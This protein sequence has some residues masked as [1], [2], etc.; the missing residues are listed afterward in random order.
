M[1]L[2]SIRWRREA[3]K[4]EAPEQEEKRSKTGKQNFP[5]VHFILLYGV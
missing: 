2:K 5:V 4:S 1:A 3:K